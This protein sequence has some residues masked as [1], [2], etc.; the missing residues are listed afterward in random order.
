MDLDTPIFIEIT[1][2]IILAIFFIIVASWVRRRSLESKN[3][4]NRAWDATAPSLREGPPAM[5]TASR[6]IAGCATWVMGWFFF[7]LFIALFWDFALFEG[8]S[9]DYVW[10]HLGEWTEALGSALLSLLRGLA[11]ALL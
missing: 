5:V 8:E 11:R 1:P 10:N 7:L 2:S 4:W 9:T 3:N 6:G